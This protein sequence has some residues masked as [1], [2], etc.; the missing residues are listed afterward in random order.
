M[1][2]TCSN[3]RCG[4]PLSDSETLCPT[5]G[6][7]VPAVPTS[8][9]LQARPRGEVSVAMTGFLNWLWQGTGY[10]VVGQNTKAIV[11]SALTVLFVIL[12]V[13]TCNVGLVFHVPYTIFGIIDGVLVAQRHNR[14]DAVGAWTFF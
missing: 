13:V 7:S 2:R 8:H 14:G 9:A 6:A 4:Q 10:F 12:D 1:I 3:P 11:F 5:C